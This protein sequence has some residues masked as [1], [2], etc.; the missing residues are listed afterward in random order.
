[1]RTDSD[2]ILI[3]VRITVNARVDPP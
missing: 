1:M 3:F 2:S